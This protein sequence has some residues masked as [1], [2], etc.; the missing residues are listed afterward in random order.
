MRKGSILNPGIEKLEP[1]LESVVCHEYLFDEIL[2]CLG[3]KA[4]VQCG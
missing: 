1:G 3:K 2:S 4:A